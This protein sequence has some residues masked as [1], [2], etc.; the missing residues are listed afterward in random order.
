MVNRG[1]VGA[2]LS[3]VSLYW[4]S[5]FSGKHFLDERSQTSF[6]FNSNAYYDFGNAYGITNEI[7][8]KVVKHDHSDHESSDHAQ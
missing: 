6:V 5:I 1:S 8:R 3:R 4:Y 7:A 2:A